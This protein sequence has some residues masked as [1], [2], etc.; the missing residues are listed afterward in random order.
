[1]AGR[2][3]VLLAALT[4]LWEACAPGGSSAAPASSSPAATAPATPSP[5]PAEARLTLQGLFHPAGAVRA[6]P[7]HVRTLIAT[8]DTI[9]ARL[10]NIEATKR[11]DFL[12]PFRPTAAYVRNADVTFVN[13]E[14]PLLAGC[15]ARPGGLVFCGD[16]RFLDGLTAIGT[17]VANLANNHVYAGPDTQR[18]A[19]PRP[20][21]SSSSSTGA[22]ST[23]GSP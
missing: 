16:P 2:L 10:V 5:T 1:M 17:R 23:S 7:A 13:L 9:P 19:A 21:W 4:I 18:T 12:W 8:G 15:P 11:Q 6:D 20:T 14:T 22:R 3:V